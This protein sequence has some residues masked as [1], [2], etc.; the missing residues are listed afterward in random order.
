MEVFNVRELAKYLNCSESS[1]RN[2]VRENKIP[3]FRISTKLNFSKETIDLWVHN[4]ELKV[5]QNC[6]KE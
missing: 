5:I 3:H 2:M 4:Q 6:N 1:I